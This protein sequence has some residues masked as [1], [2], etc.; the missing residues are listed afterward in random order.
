MRRLRAMPATLA[1]W[2][3]GTRGHGPP[4]ALSP[5]ILRPDPGGILSSTLLTLLV[6][7]A[8]YRLFARE[9]KEGCDELR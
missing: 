3:V 1:L 9:R 7:P 5:A 2:G 4:R 6:L 8:L